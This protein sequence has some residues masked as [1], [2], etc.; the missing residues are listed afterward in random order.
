MYRFIKKGYENI[1]HCRCV[2]DTPAVAAA[3]VRHSQ[4]YSQIATH[5]STVSHMDVAK[6][7]SKEIVD[8]FYLGD[9]T[10]F[11]AVS[12]T[13]LTLPTKRIV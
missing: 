3:K 1:R 7:L 11:A 4:L 6:N 12:Y 9:A 5:H 13:H 10:D 2:Q 8:M